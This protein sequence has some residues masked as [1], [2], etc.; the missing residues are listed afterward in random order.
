[1]EVKTKMQIGLLLGALT[2]ANALGALAAEAE[3]LGFDSLWA[4]DHIAFPAPILD[5]LQVLS[6]CASHTRRVRLGTCVYL[7]P[8]RHPTVVAK[9]VSS[10]D[11][12]T[13]G[14]MIFGI[15]VG[16]EFPGE[17]CAGERARWAYERGDHGCAPPVARR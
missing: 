15:G 3:A 5:P 16:G 6:C 12:I 7:L 4:G 17:R 1:M 10:L 11:F 14:R 8:L 9:M 2:D 13:A